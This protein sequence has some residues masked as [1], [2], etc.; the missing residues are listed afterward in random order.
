[1]T[2]PCF[3]SGVVSPEVA[4]DDEEVVET[5]TEGQAPLKVTVS[6]TNL[7]FT[8]PCQRRKEMKKLLTE[9]N[10]VFLPGQVAA[11]I[12]PSGCGKSALLDAICGRSRAPCKLLGTVAFNGNS[13]P[14]CEST[15]YSSNRA[16]R[17]S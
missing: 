9:V 2:K 6:L 16:R 7:G 12:G 14:W 4:A 13:A 8:V 10:A 1:M 5:E 15:S 11:V 17:F 3:S